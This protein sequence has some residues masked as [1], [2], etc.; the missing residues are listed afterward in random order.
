[1]KKKIKI[2]QKKIL[3]IKNIKIDEKRNNYKYD[4]EIVP[5]SN[6]FC[7]D[8]ILLY[9]VVEGNYVKLNFPK[10]DL[11]PFCS[12]GLID[13]LYCI[14]VKLCFDSIITTNETINI[15][16]ELYLDD[17]KKKEENF[18]Q[19]KE[20][21]PQIIEIK[22]PYN[23]TFKIDIDSNLN[24]DSIEKENNNINEQNN[25]IKNCNGF[26]IIEQEDFIKAMNGNNMNRI[27]D[28]SS[29]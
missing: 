3:L 19:I 22:N 24:I 7:L 23:E 16:I 28:S 6:D 8:P 9:S 4:I 1:M 18:K 26:E 14:N 29:K 27:N 12:G 21:N 25:N 15:P 17:E 20:D 2:F 11:L 13:C 5:C 10:V